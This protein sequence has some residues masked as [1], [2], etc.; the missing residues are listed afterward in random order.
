MG[1]RPDLQL[2]HKTT[3]ETKTLNKRILKIRYEGARKHLR[4]SRMSLARV[5]LTLHTS[6]LAGE[7]LIVPSIHLLRGDCQTFHRV[8]SQ[9]LQ[10]TYPGHGL[11]TRSI[12]EQ[13][14][15]AHGL[16][17]PSVDVN[18]WVTV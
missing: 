5:S 1:D 3:S 2:Q 16:H 11:A 10:R 17:T 4:S 7:W 12:G 9:H 18:L 13:R 14:G 8:A 6:Q 15:F